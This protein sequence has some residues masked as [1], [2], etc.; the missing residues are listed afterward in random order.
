MSVIPFPL[1]AKT[2]NPEFFTMS[3]AKCGWHE[4]LELSP[5]EMIVIPAPE[6][7]TVSGPRCVTS[8]P[9]KCPNCGAKLNKQKLPIVIRS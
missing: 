4:T 6:E 3:C 5:C 2:N 1:G 9:K 7:V 8:L